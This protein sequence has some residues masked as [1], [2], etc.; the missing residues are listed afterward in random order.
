MEFLEELM[1]LKSLEMGNKRDH[2]IMITDEAIDKVPF[3]EYKEI[4]EDEYPIIQ[5]L[6]K[7]V[8]QLSKNENN[9]NEVAITYSMD[10]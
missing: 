1:E 9:S 8:L 5:M 3:I 7:K 4:P 10:E 2:K 6:A